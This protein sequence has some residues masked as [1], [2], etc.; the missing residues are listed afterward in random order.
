MLKRCLR[1]VECLVN[2]KQKP[3][4][5]FLKDYEDGKTI[6]FE[7]KQLDVLK[8][9]ALTIYSIEFRKHQNFCDFYNSEL[10]VD[11]SLRN[12]RYRFKAGSKKWFKC[13]FVIKNI[14]KSL[15]RGLQPIINSSYWS[16]ATYDSIYFNDFIFKK[17]YC[18]QGNNKQY[19]WQFLA[20]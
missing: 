12:A 15:Y 10:C 20:L 14:Q 17:R 9:P 5:N 3:V 2:E 6:P 11:D 18:K 19:V 13:S 16:T 8:L 1:C 7:E 4:H